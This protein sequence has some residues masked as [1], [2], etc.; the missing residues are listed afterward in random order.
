M[1]F[2]YSKSYLLIVFSIFYMHM[3][4]Q[5]ALN[6]VL[7][8]KNKRNLPKAN[9]PIVLVETNTFQVKN[10]LTDANGRL[11]IQLTE[12]KKWMMHVG[13]MKGYKTLLVPEYGGRGSATVVYDL[14]RW[15]ILNKP[16]VDRSKLMLTKIPQKGIP[17]DANPIRDHSI[18]E[19]HL[20]NSRGQNWRGAHVSLVSFNLNNE[21]QAI[22]NTAGI[23]RFHIPNNQTFQIDV[24]GE[25]DFD[26]IDVGSRSVVKQ[27]SYLYEKI[28]FKE[29]LDD[30]GYIRQTFEEAPKAVSNRV[31]VKLGVQGG[32]K[33]GI[34]EDV[35]IEMAYSNKKYYG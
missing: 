16:A 7:T 11:N 31:M 13:E 18:V 5:G 15:R 24:D 28:D 21:Y 9:L 4:A 35:Y 27:M 20:Q 34:E 29:A 2:N 6:Y 32:P 19:I 23:A 12:G 17:S 26:Y 22:T 14:E 30:K 33:Y 25:V 8:V 1:N 3:H 10:Y